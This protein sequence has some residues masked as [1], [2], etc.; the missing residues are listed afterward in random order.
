MKHRQGRATHQQI[1]ALISYLEKNPHVAQG[2]FTTMN[3]KE[4]LQG[5]WEE[6][7]QLLNSM[8]PNGKAKDVK[9][10]KTTWRDHKSKVS[11]KIQRLRKARAST[12]NKSINITITDFD[13][14]I[15]GI[16]EH[17]Y[18]QGLSNVSDSFPEEYNNYQQEIQR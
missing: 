14:R 9:S 6:L 8:V 7:T 1:E 3:A 12:R 15:L 17:E 18:V 10:W 13:K 16:I 2:K 5:S 11:E 4:H